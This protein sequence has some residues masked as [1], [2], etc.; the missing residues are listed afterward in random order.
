LGGSA[1]LRAEII[2]ADIQGF[3]AQKHQLDAQ[4]A[5]LRWALNRQ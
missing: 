3:E 2:H 5:E 1:H 4:I